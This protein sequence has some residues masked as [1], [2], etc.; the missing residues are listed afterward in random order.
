MLLCSIE[1]GGKQPTNVGRAKKARNAGNKRRQ[2]SRLAS[3]AHAEASE[4]RSDQG[5][6][7]LHPDDLRSA[8]MRY[9][10][11]VAFCLCSGCSAHMLAATLL[12]YKHQQQSSKLLLQEDRSVISCCAQLS[13]PIKLPFVAACMQ[14]TMS[15][16]DCCVCRVDQH[17]NEP[18]NLGVSIGAQDAAGP[19]MGLHAQDAAGSALGLH[20]SGAHG[21]AALAIGQH[22]HGQHGIA[23]QQSASGLPG[24]SPSIQSW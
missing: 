10:A 17:E 8:D 12:L 11:Y 22:G 18:G 7:D 20:A 14:G 9:I 19:G 13:G 23:D 4:V 6:Y 16:I 21:S 5:D 3:V 15:K 2:R 1:P 24:A